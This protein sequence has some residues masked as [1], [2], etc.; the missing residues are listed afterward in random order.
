MATTCR[1]RPKAS[2][3]GWCIFRIVV[4]DPQQI[5]GRQLSQQE[6]RVDVKGFRERLVPF[7]P[8][9]S[10]V[11][12]GRLPR[13]VTRARQHPQRSIAA[14]DHP[15]LRERRV[16]NRRLAVVLEALG[17]AV[18]AVT[19]RAAWRRFLPGRGR[20]ALDARDALPR[21]H[22]RPGARPGC[23]V[24]RWRRE[25]GDRARVT[26][27]GRAD[28]RCNHDRKSSVQKFGFHFGEPAALTSIRSRESDLTSLPAAIS[29]SV[30]VATRI[31]RS[32]FRLKS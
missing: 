20:R 12:R 6:T 31:S 14:L 5:A 28:A 19:I 29:S 32:A 7:T 8:C 24:D 26:R 3:S 15:V 4:P 10:R 25:W 17:L 30:N 16:A 1:H 18:A 13:P 22:T 9:P 2:L 27:P 23:E 11:S 21:A